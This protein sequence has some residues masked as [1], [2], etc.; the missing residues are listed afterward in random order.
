MG[1]S[2]Y[3]YSNYLHFVFVHKKITSKGMNGTVC[4]FYELLQGDDTR[5]AGRMNRN[6]IVF[7]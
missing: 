4:T 5:S 2:K 6:L 7:I 3:F 1:N